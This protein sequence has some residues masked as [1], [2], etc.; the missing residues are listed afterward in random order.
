M[1]LKF[2]STEVEN[3]YFDATKVDRV[4]HNGTLVYESTIYVD[5]PTV[6]G[7]F[8]YDKGTKTA[9]ITGYDSAAM[10][11]SGAQSAI[12]AGT[13]HVYFTLNKGYAWTDGTT[14]KLDLTWS[15]AKRAITIPS[16]S[17]TSFTWVEGTSHSV[18][19]KNVDT[20]YVSQSGTT[21][22]TD[23]SS[24]IGTKNTVTWSLKNTSSTYW[25]DSTT[26]NKTATWSAS[27]VDG[28][29]HYT[30]D[31]YN[32]G[33]NS[34]KLTRGAI[35]SDPIYYTTVDWGSASKPYITAVASTASA[36]YVLATQKYL[37]K[38][39]HA[40]VKTTGQ[41]AFVCSMKYDTIQSST[42]CESA[43]SGYSGT[44]WGEIWG[45]DTSAGTY[46]GGLYGIKS[47]SGGQDGIYIQRIWIA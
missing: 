41:M 37:G 10:T 35:G 14:N 1:A 9:T 22:Q 25:T 2:N 16:L 39:M 45:K 15:I 4:F 38:T 6:S 33:W 5:K 34:G 19:V 18:T 7:S 3:V 43:S 11:I 17:A 13:Y 47:N 46:Y 44:D 8:T 26:A 30:N 23:S 29:S 32:R 40:I 42:A 20:N 27:W 21:S 12:E 36:H 31:L 24:N 28:T